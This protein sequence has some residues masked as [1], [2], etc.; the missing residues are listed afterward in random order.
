MN[1][2]NCGANNRG[3]AA[4]CR[5]CGRLLHNACPRCAAP[6]APDANFCD[7]CGSPLSPRAWMIGHESG[8]TND[9]WGP[10][11]IL[12][13]AQ[14]TNRPVSPSP[15]AQLDRYIPRE[16]MDK[17]A[18]ARGATAERRV[19]TLLFCDIQGSTALAGQ[20]DPEEWTEI[21]NGAFEQMVRPIYA[22]EGTVARLMGDGL[23]AFFGAPIAHED[24]PRRAVLA[25][26]SIVEGI[27]AYRDSLPPAAAELDV[28]VGIN[29]GLVVVGAIGSDLRLEYSAI[30][31]AI[32]LA[33]RMEQTAAPGTVQIAEDTYRLVE[34]QFEIES[35][36]EIAVKGK[37]QPVPAYRVLRRAGGPARR[38]ASLRAPLVN[39]IMAWEQL[40]RSFDALNAGRGGILFL[41]GDAGLGKTR[42]IEEAAERLL[43]L[44]NPPANCYEA[45]AVSYE[46][47]RPY[48]LLV[49][50][51]RQPLGL[52]IG[53]PP[54]QIRRRIAA[55]V[56]HPDDAQVLMA[57][58]G[59][60]PGGGQEIGGE[61]FAGR[62][63]NCMGRFWRAQTA[64]GPLVLVLD[65][66]QWLDA[67]SAA[68]LLRSFRLVETEPVLFVC[69]LRRERRTPGWELKETAGRD[70]PHRLIEAALHPLNDGES[71]ALLAGLLGAADLPELPAG[72]ILDKAEGNP[73]FLEEVVRHLV[74]QGDL[75]RGEDGAW[76]VTP[77]TAGISLP[78]SIQALLTAR[79]DRLDEATR[80]TLQVASVIG[81]HFLRSPL[82]ALVDDPDALDGQL[83]DLQRAELIREVSRV[84]E[85]SFQFDHT[86]TQEAVYHTILLKQRRAMHL[87]TAEVIESI[88]AGNLTAV[89]PIL[90]HHFIEGDAPER[91]LPY[92]LM[93][94]ETAV[95]L[96]ATAEAANHYERALPIARRL[97]DG[98]R[99]LV[100]IATN[101]GRALELAARYAEAKAHYEAMEQLAQERGEPA[102]ELAADIG[103][104][105]LFGNVTPFYD[106][107]RGR[108]LMERAV[109][110]AKA[111]GDRKAEV[112]ILWNLVNIDRF[113]INGLDKAIVNGER[114]VTLARELGLVEELAYLLN[115][116][117]DIYRT[118]GESET[119]LAY[120]EEAREM[121][122]ALGNE[123]M[124]ANNLTSSGM[125]ETIYGSLASTLEFTAESIRITS[126]L[127]NVWGEAYGRGVRGQ[128]LSLMGEYGES[129]DEL[130]KAIGLARKAGFIGGQMISLSFL[131]RAYLELGDVRSAIETA[132]EGAAISRSQL[133]QFYGMAAGRLA[134]ALIVDGRLDAAA[135]A[136][137]D[138]LAMREKQQIF[139]RL[140][141]S[142]ARIDLAL[143]QPYDEAALAAALEPLDALKSGR[144][145]G[146]DGIIYAA[147]G[148]LLARL[149]RAD[150]AAE[151]LEQAAAAAREND[152][153]GWL[154]KILAAWADV[155]DER[156][157]HD[158]A[159]E[160]RAGAAAEID[161]VAGR[162]RPDELRV[163]FLGQA[164]V[165]ACM[166]TVAG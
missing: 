90:A 128:T 44:L 123:P 20:L 100:E 13:A 111:T 106:P 126:R 16:L 97:P 119:G 52:S 157:N 86:V 150:D 77:Q 54:E 137:A 139:G 124:L 136:L 127:G 113:D 110:L 63:V 83:L 98:S 81:R 132:G 58:Y 164:A 3:G 33:A 30:G 69:A 162:I 46:T 35:L 140:E 68:C 131:S 159:A 156:G 154:W 9:E 43:P 26:L 5:N 109:E 143:A 129:I 27:C 104:G 11:A 133:P 79:V 55:A 88:R 42:L 121:W 21:V 161:Y 117:G 116:V 64:A 41:T 48:G 108:D 103:L 53:D 39:R 15:T 18:E 94:G 102:L 2:P 89:A 19:V 60:T 23:L 166:E 73:L 7:T 24:D 160:L 8:N 120:L 14:S 4:F 29:T 78:D 107:A 99:P 25:G 31:D 112:R 12:P 151:S 135:E 115:D 155:E 163:S 50:L 47:S 82:A 147:E 165:R 95:R 87:R 70:L 93:A 56:E 37:A 134:A 49:R 118:A 59:L 158:A 62:L 38:V 51:L 17:L 72:L 71:R 92:L 1:C 141:I 65:E 67:S 122:I 153:R 144:S 101:H 96:H 32:N 125:W 10:S 22:Y 114:G 34:G 36:G 80:R 61:G 84:P 105:T 40:E 66:L 85:P 6:A 57:L 142:L 146:W 130:Q 28:R 76:S 45:S 74:E 91:A 138:P 75:T 145:R 148:K 149:G 152:M